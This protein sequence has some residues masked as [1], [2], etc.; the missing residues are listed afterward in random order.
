MSARRRPLAAMALLAVLAAGCTLPGRV[1][2]PVEVTAT[3]D[4]VG[5]LVAG[6]SVQVADVRVG[7]VVGIELTD[8]Y[9]AHV[10]MSLRDGLEVPADSEAILR[11]TSLLGEKFIELRAPE[12]DAPGLQAAVVN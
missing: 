11:T 12:G 7:S 2:G 1:E 6:H 8:D 9:R 4:D 3:F 5:D 10:T